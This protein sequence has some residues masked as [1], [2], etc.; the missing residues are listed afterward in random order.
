MKL[1]YFFLFAYFILFIVF[2]IY[3]FNYREPQDSPVA[4]SFT[5]PS[6]EKNLTQ[7]NL[8]VSDD[9]LL[10]KNIKLQQRTNFIPAK[11][12]IPSIVTFQRE[13]EKSAIAIQ[14]TYYI[15]SVFITLNGYITRGW[16]NVLESPIDFSL[17]YGNYTG[18]FMKQIISFNIPSE[19]NINKTIDFNQ[20][21]TL[22]GDFIDDIKPSKWFPFDS[23]S[24]ELFLETP[25]GSDYSLL[26]NVPKYFITNNIA[27][28][29]I[30][31]TYPFDSV[32]KGTQI[33]GSGKNLLYSGRLDTNQYL[34]IKLGI[35]REISKN[36]IIYVILFLIFLIS[37]C[38]TLLPKSNI[39]M[40]FY[41]YPLFFFS[42]LIIGFLNFG[43][44]LNKFTLL[45]LFSIIPFLIGL[46]IFDFKNRDNKW[47]KLFYRWIF[48]LFL[49]I[50][51]IIYWYNSA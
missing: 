11:D 48:W 14:G 15:L 7:I 46:F 45:H 23:Y 9:F 27:V 18:P 39:A 47:N 5:L 44:P 13:P 17:P 4:R 32:G 28:E 10:T 21:L 31:D 29:S 25:Q 24:I 26:A 16:S 38:I 41:H 49:I 36:L 22:Q 12:S 40:F 19:V 20:E 51:L 35:I 6:N 50:V 42:I 3:V 1:K 33:I 34:H 2:F 8:Q 37:F 30:T 43:L